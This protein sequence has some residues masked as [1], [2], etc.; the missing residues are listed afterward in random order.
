M[1]TINNPNSHASKICFRI[2]FLNKPLKIV[3]FTVVHS[4][5]LLRDEPH[6]THVSGL[7]C[8]GPQELNVPEKRLRHPNVDNKRDQCL[9]EKI[10]PRQCVVYSFLTLFYH[11]VL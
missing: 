4:E 6:P 2:I 1:S 5:I 11:A 10:Y 8:A 9:L 7:W 3:R